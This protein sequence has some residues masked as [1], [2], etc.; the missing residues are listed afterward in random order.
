MTEDPIPSAS[1][2]AKAISPPPLS[3]DPLE[4]PPAPEL[5]LDED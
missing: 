2:V 5:L 1:M 3:L 4:P